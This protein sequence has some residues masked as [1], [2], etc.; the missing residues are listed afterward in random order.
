MFCFYAKLKALKD[1]LKK[2]NKEV[3]GGLGQKVL[4]ARQ[5]LAMAQVQFVSYRGNTNC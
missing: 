5:D 4:K 3:C 2:K 1:V